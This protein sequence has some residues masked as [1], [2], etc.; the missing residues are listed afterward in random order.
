MPKPS[1]YEAQDASEDE[2]EVEN[3]E[4]EEDASEGE[5]DA[6]GEE[7]EEED[8]S[9]EEERPAKKQR[10]GVSDFVLDEAEV[11]DDDEDEYEDEEAEI[12]EVEADELLTADSGRKHRELA[13]ML[14]RDDGETLDYFSRKYGEKPDVGGEEE[15]EEYDFEAHDEPD[16]IKQQSLLPTIKDPK[17][18]M[19]KCTMGKER[20][21]CMALMRKY[22]ERE[23]SGD[24]LQI[25]S[26]IAPQHI[27]GYIYVEAH[28]QA[29]VKAAIHGLQVLALGQY[30]QELV[31]IKE[32]PQ[33]LTVRKTIVDLEPRSWVRVKRGIYKEDLGQ[34]VSME[35]T[36]NQVVVKLVPRIS[37]DTIRSH[38]G[39]IGEKRKKP[40]KRAPQ[41]LF[42][43]QDVR[44]FGGE[45]TRIDGVYDF[46]EGNRYK[47][48]YLF[49]S[50][51]LQSLAINGIQPTLDELQR[52]QGVNS[53]G[54]TSHE[55]GAELLPFTNVIFSK[56]DAVEVI[57]GEL[58]N[59]TGVVDK[60]ENG[61]ITV[62]PKHEDLKG[63][64][65]ALEF[66]A[67]Q[68]RKFFKMGDHVK[69]VAGQ[70]TGETGM[71][72]RVE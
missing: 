56:G 45:V 2:E 47:D 8:L 38:G 37:Y 12:N 43:S 65:D 61:M 6:V 11:S 48:G 32:M 36:G 72:V 20:H 51:P 54:V 22:V 57:E 17:I 9:E 62:I 39:A 52:F 35:E 21:V 34:V 66:P 15:D 64:N 28:R 27:K 44:S 42:N 10:G 26:I 70:Y 40:I 23:Y 16:L 53:D 14:S 19:V 24:P 7:E 33:I 18:W 1:K 29:H 55:V 3:E 30:K 58:I 41:K 60:V 59:L 67:S 71:V 50:Y 13:S 46:F 69:V 5:A 63:M 25:M 31:P 49:K 68:L 4:E